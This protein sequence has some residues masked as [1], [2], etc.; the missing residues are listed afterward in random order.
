LVQD[1]EASLAGMRRCLGWPDTDRV[2]R[3]TPDARYARLQPRLD[4]SAVLELVE[5]KNWTS[6]HG[7]Y[8][9]KWGPGPHAIRL[10]VRDLAAKAEDLRARGTPFYSTRSLEGREIL[11]VDPGHLEGIVVEFE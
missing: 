1:I 9:G 10:E 3:D 7:E 5:A 6:R 11:A 8:F 4:T 2:V